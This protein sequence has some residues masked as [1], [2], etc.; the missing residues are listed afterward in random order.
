MSCFRQESRC[1]EGQRKWQSLKIKCF[2]FNGIAVIWF[3][4]SRL[5]TGLH[6]PVTSSFDQLGDSLPSVRTGIDVFWKCDVVNSQEF[7]N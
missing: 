7:D 4:L 1:W 6:E 3:S 5:K 2:V